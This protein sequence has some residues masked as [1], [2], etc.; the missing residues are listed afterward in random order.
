M[1]IEVWVDIYALI[2]LMPIPQSNDFKHSIRYKRNNNMYYK[3]LRSNKVTKVIEV[4]ILMNVF[5]S[6]KRQI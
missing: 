1:K 2:F 5:F 3:I 4:K 6:K